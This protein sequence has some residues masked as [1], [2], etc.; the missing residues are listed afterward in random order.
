METDLIQALKDEFGLQE[1]DPTLYSPL[2]LAYIGDAVYELIIR[3]VVINTGNR[4][5][6][7]FHNNTESLVKAEA[8]AKLAASILDDLSDEE[9]VMYKRGRNAK[10]VT[11]PKNAKMSDYRMATGFEALCGYLYLSGQTGRL[12]ELVHTGLTNIGALT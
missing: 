5:V 10:S 1:Q 6:G 11:M 9:F 7:E 3:T 12:L 8:Q 4:P 2:V